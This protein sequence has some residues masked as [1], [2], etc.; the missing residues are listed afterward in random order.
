MGWFSDSGKR[1]KR[2]AAGKAKVARSADAAAR[3][4]ARKLAKNRRQGRYP[5]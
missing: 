5:Q 3:R 2:K 1:A 4:R